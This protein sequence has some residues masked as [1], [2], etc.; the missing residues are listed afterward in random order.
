MPDKKRT[1][2]ILALQ[3]FY[4]KP[5]AK[6][7]LELVLS[8]TTVIFFAIFAIRPTLLTMFDLV[9]QIEDKTKLEQ[10]LSQK[11]AALSTV[12]NQYLQLQDRLAVI[13]QAIPNDPQL[14]YTLTVIEKTASDLNLVIEGMNIAEIP[15]S[16]HQDEESDPNALERIDLP[17]SIALSGN[18]LD[19][20]QFVENLMNYRRSFVVDTIVFS[21]EKVRGVDQLK[22][23]VVVSA[24]YYGDRSLLENQE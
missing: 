6:V 13:D 20:R 12:Q 3:D 1:D 14:V 21:T 8:L 17:I 9:K 4:Q 19:I 22:A 24:P 23:T 11:I 18:Y 5:M 7:S 10:Q 16:R 15:N 2:L